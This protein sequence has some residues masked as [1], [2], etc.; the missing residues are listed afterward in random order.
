MLAYILAIAVGLGSLAI[1]IAAFFFPEVHRKSDFLWSGLGLF[2]ALI[3]WTCAGR[4]TGAVLLGQMASVGLIGW[5]G[6]QTLS[7]RRQVTPVAEQTKIPTK[8]DK[9]FKFPGVGAKPK[10]EDKIPLETTPESVSTGEASAEST[11]VAEF[12]AEVSESSSETEVPTVVQT[13]TPSESATTETLKSLTQPG[14]TETEI[15]SELETPV[16][17]EAT[18]GEVKPEAKL[19]KTETKKKAGGFS[20]LLAPVNELVSSI[21]NAFGKKD[22][23]TTQTPE[24]KL[25]VESDTPEV[26]REV[27]V[28]EK[29]EEGIAQVEITQTEEVGVTDGEEEDA[30]AKVELGESSVIEEEVKVT[31]GEIEAEETV[32]EIESQEELN[33]PQ[34]DVESKD[35]S[36]EVPPE[37]PSVSNKDSNLEKES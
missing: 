6:W 14:E 20:V 32:S 3:L 35:K 25:E 36:Q 13:P 11:S 1:Y 12:P 33:P 34:E 7:L 19:D 37:V 27:N 18:E 24:T 16:V 22:K 23:G 26:E 4:I 8:A 15:N 29:E 5:F 30:I 28:T 2:Y 9:S 21:K 10:D 31:P 17:G